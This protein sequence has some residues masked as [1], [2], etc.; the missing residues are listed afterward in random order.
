MSLFLIK[1]KY[2]ISLDDL[3]Y[4]YIVE[5]SN[6][7][8]KFIQKDISNK[9]LCLL[10]NEQSRTKDI[11]LMRIKGYSYYEICEKYGI[12]ESSARVIDYRAKKKIRDILTKEENTH[13]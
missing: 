5:E 1:E 2:T 4:S 9:I 6:L 7:E 13:E 12:S 10:D 8:E 11:V 3:A